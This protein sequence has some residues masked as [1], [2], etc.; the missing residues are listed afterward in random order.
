VRNR[1]T[2]V[3]VLLALLLLLSQ[4]MVL[5][6]AVSHFSETRQRTADTKQLPIEQTC[7][8]CLAHAQI[9]S[10]LTSQFALHLA[11]AAPDTVVVASPPLLLSAKTFTAFRSRAPPSL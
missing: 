1:K 3:H 10:G 4:Q 8:H 6:H 5:A 7:E 9:G 2:I 11:D